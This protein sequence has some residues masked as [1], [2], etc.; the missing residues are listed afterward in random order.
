M[1]D[2]EGGG[3][4]AEPGRGVIP[5]QVG[6]EV[7][8]G[9]DA[10]HD[11][12]DDL[13]NDLELNGREAFGADAVG[14]H[15]EAVFKESNAPADDDDLPEGFVAELQVAIPGKGHEDVGDDEKDYCPHDGLDAGGRSRVADERE[16]AFAE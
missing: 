2:E 7:E 1:K 11:E 15:L 14:G 13:L 9:K 8:S 12:G 10:E 6:A 3:D 5:A 16:A 4:Q